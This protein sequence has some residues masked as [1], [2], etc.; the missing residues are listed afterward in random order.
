MSIAYLADARVRSLLKRLGLT[1]EMLEYA[2]RN[3]RE[4]GAEELRAQID[5]TL[6]E[7]DEARLQ[8]ANAAQNGR[9]GEI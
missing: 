4:Q 8:A 5:K 2:E 9:G 3:D 7:L 6:R 1:Y